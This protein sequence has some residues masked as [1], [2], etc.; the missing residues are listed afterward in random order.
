MNIVIKKRQSEA[1]DKIYYYFE[2]GR[3]S[4]QRKATGIYTYTKPKD[5]LEK[6]TKRRHYEEQP[7]IGIGHPGIC[8]E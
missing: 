1:K 2:W 8:I 3:S 5:Q 4:G 6:N 7:P